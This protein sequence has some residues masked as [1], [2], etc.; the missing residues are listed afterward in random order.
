MLIY[1]LIAL[2]IV[3]GIAVGMWMSNTSKDHVV[4]QVQADA[5]EAEGMAK[6]VAADVQAAKDAIAGDASKN[7]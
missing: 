7:G 5:A 4:E 2:V 3:L 6:Q 1:G